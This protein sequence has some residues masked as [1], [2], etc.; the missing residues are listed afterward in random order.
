MLRVVGEHEGTTAD[1]AAAAAA[2]AA[3]AAAAADAAA[4]AAA[5]A[6]GVQQLSMSAPGPHNVVISSSSVR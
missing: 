2:D 4:A 3:A 6:D 1:A 5:A